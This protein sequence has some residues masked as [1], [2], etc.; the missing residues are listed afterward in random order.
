MFIVPLF[1]L[2]AFML[3]IIPM[4]AI[5]PILVFIGVVTANQVVRET[6]KIEV[7]VIFICL[8][9]WIANWA[10]TMVNSVMAAAG[11]SAA[12]IG[13]DVLAHKGVFYQGL[14]HLGN[15][16]PLASM[17][18]GCVAIFAIINKPLRGA[19]A[20]AFGALLALFGVIHAPIVGFA[21][22]SSMMF[23]T[24]YLMMGA[25]FVVKH[26]LDRREAATQAVA[27]VSES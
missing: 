12:K 2:G 5:V 23:V 16:A 8:F 11:T 6:P 24:A 18:W 3:A 10:L 26:V 9:P 13:P 17:L 15:G 4:T 27:P 21:Q 1:G 19:V 7:P 20:A 22:G 25:M 14:V